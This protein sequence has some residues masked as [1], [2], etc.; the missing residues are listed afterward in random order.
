M[1]LESDTYFSAQFQPSESTEV[2]QEEKSY[3][4]Q[5][6]CTAFAYQE[7]YLIII[8]PNITTKTTM[9]QYN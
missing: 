8:L 7:V 4:S 1:Q 2:Q 6:M 3:D 9:W 5:H